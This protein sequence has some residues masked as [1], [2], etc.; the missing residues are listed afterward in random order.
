MFSNSLKWLATFA[1][2]RRARCYTT[3]PPMSPLTLA[4]SKEPELTLKLDRTPL[5]CAVCGHLIG[6][7]DEDA[8]DKACRLR[9]DR[10]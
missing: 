10:P 7:C 6:H 5:R 2:R 1:S 3:P 8:H 4:S 9:K